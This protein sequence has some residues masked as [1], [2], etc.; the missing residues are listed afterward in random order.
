MRLFITGAS[1]YVGS[2][3]TEKAV[4]QGHE[5]V[6]LIRSD[7]GADKV[8]RLGAIPY[9]GSLED[10]DAL[11]RA[12]QESDAVLHLGFVHEFDRPYSELLEIDIAAI[13]AMG[14]ALKGPGKALISTSGTSVVEPN[15]GAE[16]DE[17][18]PLASS[19]LRRRGQSEQ[20]TIRL[21]SLGVR[22]MVIR[23]APYVYGRGGSSFVPINMLTAAK[24]GFAPYVGD[25]AV[26][27]SA[28]DVDASAELYLLALQKGSAGEIYNCTT[29]TDVRIKDL[30]QAIATALGVSAKSVTLEQASEM[31]GSSTA[32]LLA[33]DKA[34]EMY[35]AWTAQFLVSENR[36][37]SGKAKRELGWQPRPKF[38]LC[39]DIVHGSYKKMASELK[40]QAVP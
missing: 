36:A 37:S 20:E 6:G 9:K 4:R 17:E 18:T 26:M 31:L 3:V 1:G 22:A 34:N 35:G 19:L 32:Q 16:T 11:A 38:S 10:T 29:E 8:R 40:T 14:A 39:D 24:Y 28:G 13:K 15:N 2:V 33:R 5:V 12:A 25:G 30:A 21:V 27:T 7:K 23:L